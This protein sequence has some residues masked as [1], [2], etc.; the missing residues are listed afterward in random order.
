MTMP[1]RMA[2]ETI[3]T[4]RKTVEQDPGNIEARYQLSLGYYH[5]RRVK[6]AIAEMQRV[7]I[8]DPKHS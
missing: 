3:E 5:A 6:E 4:Y 2:E 7:I 1:H 8:L